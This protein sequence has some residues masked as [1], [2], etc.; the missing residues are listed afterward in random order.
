[1]SK[2]FDPTAP[3]IA[4][5]RL[6]K[7][8]ARGRQQVAALTDVTFEIKGG[9]FVAITGHSG[10]G[11]TTLLNLIGCMDEPS[12]GALRIGGR[13]VQAFSEGE[14][15]AFRREQIGFIFQHFGL[16]PTLNVFENIALPLVF[17]GRTA[18]PDV[19]Q[20]LDR[21]GLKHRRDHKPNE[22]SGGEMQ[23]VAIARALVQ[24]PSLLLADEPTG[25]LDSASGERLV[26]LL[27]ELHAGGLTI[28]IV[29]HNPAVAAVAQRS[30]VLRD[31]RVVQP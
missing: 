15:T 2:I 13:E 29:T 31:G 23:R 12:S 28:V 10:S 11:K 5:S 1:M 7:S 4:A 25:N 27:K 16:M 30:I 24:R 20:L 6:S 9:E 26:G 21:V 14:R 17:S 18:A 19:E 8:Y 22:L 3:L